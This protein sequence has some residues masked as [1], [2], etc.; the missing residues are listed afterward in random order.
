MM[1]LGILIFAMGKQE[2]YMKFGL[3]ETDVYYDIL[4]VKFQAYFAYF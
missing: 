1:G 3:N 4:R 2:K